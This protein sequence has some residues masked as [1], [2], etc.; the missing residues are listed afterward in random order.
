MSNSKHTL[1]L[2]F[3]A[4]T[5]KPSGNSKDT[6]LL[7]RESNNPSANGLKFV[8]LFRL[9]KHRFPM[10]KLSQKR[11]GMRLVYKPEP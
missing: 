9:S 11:T 8:L 5:E 1:L 6:L 10:P 7:S 3:S 2:P 4:V